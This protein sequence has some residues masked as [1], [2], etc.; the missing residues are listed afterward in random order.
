ML[1]TGGFS[2]FT[3]QKEKGLIAPERYIYSILVLLIIDEESL[4]DKVNLI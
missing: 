1:T 4:K 3:L 2:A